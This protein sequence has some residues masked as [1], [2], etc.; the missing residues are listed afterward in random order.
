LHIEVPDILEKKGSIISLPDMCRIAIH[1]C[2]ASKLKRVYET[3]PFGDFPRT[4]LIYYRRDETLSPV[5][6]I[7]GAS[8]DFL[9]SGIIQG[10][11]KNREC[12][13]TKGA[14]K[15]GS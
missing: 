7:I 9:R 8:I 12:R 1:S 11:G 6:G 13:A 2:G 10:A 14:G 15:N 3:R 4:V 5:G